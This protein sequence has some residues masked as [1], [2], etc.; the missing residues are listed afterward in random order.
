MIRLYDPVRITHPKLREFA[1]QAAW[2]SVVTE[3]ADYLEDLNID[4]AHAERLLP[5]FSTP[6]PWEFDA[7]IV[8]VTIL[9]RNRDA[10]ALDLD[11]ALARWLRDDAKHWTLFV[12]TLLAPW[13][14]R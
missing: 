8:A 3:A 5:D 13:Q 1:F 14:E 7:V 12:L 11:E 4:V 2:I 9:R 6:W 10:A